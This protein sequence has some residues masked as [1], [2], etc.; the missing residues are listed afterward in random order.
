MDISQND[1]YASFLIPTLKVKVDGCLAAGKNPEYSEDSESN[2]EKLSYHINDLASLSGIKP[3]NWIKDL[4]YNGFNEA[5]AVNAKTYLDSL[6][7]SFRLKSR[8]ISY[9]RDSLVKQIS[10]KI[11]NEN[12]IKLRDQNYNENL[13]NFL[14]N[15]LAAN[16]IYDSEHQLIQ[17]ADPVFMRPG[18]KF[19]RAHYY[20]PYKQL[21]NWKIGTLYFNLVAIWLMVF[22][23]FVTLY[24][25]VLKRFIRLLESLKLPILRKFGRDLLQF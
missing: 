7:T 24:Y 13:A 4:N 23:L 18:S 12:F 3:G 6:K 22:L 2:I 5:V 1:W 9:K 10:G 8:S 15:R 14:L 20:A 11:G 25:N 19:G 21:G 17:K 16:K